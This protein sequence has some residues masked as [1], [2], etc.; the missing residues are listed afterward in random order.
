MLNL[1]LESYRNRFGEAIVKAVLIFIL[2]CHLHMDMTDRERSH[3]PHRRLLL[4]LSVALARA[5]ASAARA[6]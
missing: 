3:W 4:G 1:D 6:D 2:R 5:P